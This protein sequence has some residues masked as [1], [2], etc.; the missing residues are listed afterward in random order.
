MKYTGISGIK[1]LMKTSA[2]FYTALFE[3]WLYCMLYVY[4]LESPVGKK[5]C[6]SDEPNYC[7]LIKVESWRRAEPQNC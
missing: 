6:I 5:L 2:M 3:I 1:T 7:R 4:M